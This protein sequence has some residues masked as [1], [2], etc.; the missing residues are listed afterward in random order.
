[1]IPIQGK[2][3]FAANEHLSSYA[4]RFALIMAIIGVTPTYGF[5]YFLNY[6]SHSAFE[7]IVV[8]PSIYVVSVMGLTIGQLLLSV[9]ITIS[10]ILFAA[11]IWANIYA[12]ISIYP[13]MRVPV[14]AIL[15]NLCQPI[16]IRITPLSVIQTNDY[17]AHSVKT[18][19]LVF[20]KMANE[21][22]SQQMGR[23]IVCYTHTRVID[24]P[25]FS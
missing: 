12:M 17:D 24:P 21:I 6:S 23:F 20:T 18:K 3:I 25:I 13:N 7:N 11:L 10:S 2:K 15:G 16:L 4:V 22:V 1:M 5:I 9:S 8:L 14:P 19:S